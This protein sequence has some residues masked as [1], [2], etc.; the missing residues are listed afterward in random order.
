MPR[1][2]ITGVTGQDGAYLAQLLLE[3]GYEVF[4]LARRTSN[5]GFQDGRLRWLGV[6]DGIRIVDG[7]LTDLSSAVRLMAELGPDEVYNLGAPSFVGT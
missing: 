7:D 3:K 5:G 1:A 4:G 6:L 2:L